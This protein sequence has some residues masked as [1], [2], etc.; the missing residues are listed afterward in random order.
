MYI[1]HPLE[2]CCHSLFPLTTTSSGINPCSDSIQFLHVSNSPSVLADISGTD[3]LA[4]TIQIP[5]R[6][7]VMI[8]AKSVSPSQQL[9]SRHQTIE[10]LQRKWRSPRSLKF[11]STVTT[12]QNCHSTISATSTISTHWTAL[13][14]ILLITLLPD[15]TCIPDVNHWLIS[16]QQSHAQLAKQYTSCTHKYRD[17]TANRGLVFLSEWI[18]TK[19]NADTSTKMPCP[20]LPRS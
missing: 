20:R 10:K 7:W 3:F 13:S 6:L 9:C 17:P 4:C 8:S 19:M 12:K 14:R 11:G 1:L 18:P 15:A 2:C 5:S 16:R